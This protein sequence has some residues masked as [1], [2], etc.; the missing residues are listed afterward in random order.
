MYKPLQTEGL[1]E[2]AIKI[3]KLPKVNDKK[4]RMV[5][6]THGKEPTLVAKGGYRTPA[7]RRL[8]LFPH[9]QIDFPVK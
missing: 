5:V 1:K 6:I 3:S 2:I 9:S 4:S 7:D 8:I